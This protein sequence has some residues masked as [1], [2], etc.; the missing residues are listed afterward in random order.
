MTK[1]AYTLKDFYSEIACSV[2][3]YGIS[4]ILLIYARPIKLLAR[5]TSLG[6]D[7]MPKLV[8]SFLIV[9][10]SVLLTQA[11]WRFF[12]QRAALL[13]ERRNMKAE[14]KAFRFSKILDTH[15]DW[16]SMAAV[17][18]YVFTMQG[19]GYIVSTMVYIALQAFILS[20]KGIRKNW[21]IGVVAVAAPLI[22]YLLFSRVFGMVLPAGIFSF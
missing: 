9:C 19:L 16:L 3:V 20:V 12:R 22:I 17:C 10:G 14:K 8:A 15:A 21:L 13:S 1:K 4:A 18:V 5:T 11:L 6:S 2:F 7:F